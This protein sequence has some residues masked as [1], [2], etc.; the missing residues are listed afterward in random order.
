MFYDYS[1]K[2]HRETNNEVIFP[3]RACILSHLR[4]T[5]IIRLSNHTNLHEYEWTCG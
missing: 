4:G 2:K 3:Y 1:Y 5:I